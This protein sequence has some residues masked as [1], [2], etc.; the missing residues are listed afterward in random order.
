V[1]GVI[2][3]IRFVLELGLLASL[4]A[5]GWELAGG[6]LVGAGLA[7]AAAIGGAAVWGAWIAPRS[8]RRMPDPQRFTLEVVLCALGGVALWAAWTPA[9]GIVFAGASTA[10]AALTRVVGESAPRTG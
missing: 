9:A 10:V 3:G 6:G 7:T 8:K 5:G 1:R 4:A 2:L